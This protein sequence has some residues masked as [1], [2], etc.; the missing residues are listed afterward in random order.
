MTNI[1]LRK[2]FKLTDGRAAAVA[3][4]SSH[5]AVVGVTLPP[6]LTRTI[7]C[8][9][10]K[11]GKIGASTTN[12]EL[13]ILRTEFE[14]KIADWNTDVLPFDGDDEPSYL[15]TFADDLPFADLDEEGV[16]LDPSDARASKASRKR[17]E[18]CSVFA[19]AAELL[20]YSPAG[21]IACLVAASLV[22]P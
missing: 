16:Q 18:S 14:K 3:G 9:A 8:S 11:S 19:A 2:K 15:D 4:A 6:P 10:T 1:R 13:R 17:V 5:R 21:S 20:T 12:N 22:L 7:F